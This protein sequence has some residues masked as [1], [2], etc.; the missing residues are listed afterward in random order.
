MTVEPKL[1]FFKTTYT[2]DLQESM[3]LRISLIKL[4]VLTLT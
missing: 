1:D 2:L 3:L 4:H